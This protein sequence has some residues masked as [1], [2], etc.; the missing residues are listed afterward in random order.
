VVIDPHGMVRRTLR[1]H[2]MQSEE[3]EEMA[4]DLLTSP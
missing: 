1:G 3:V 2:S 4:T